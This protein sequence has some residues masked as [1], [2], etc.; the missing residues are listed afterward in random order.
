[1]S[2]LPTRFSLK[3]DKD[4]LGLTLIHPVLLFVFADLNLY[5]MERSLPLV[6]TRII[7]ERIDGV[8]VSD[9]HEEGRAIDVSLI[10]WTT[11]DIDEVIYRFN[12]KYAEAYGAYS[13][14]DSKPRLIVDPRHGTAPHLHIQIRK[15][16]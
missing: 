16:R 11:D 9:T 3:Y 15:F 10:G 8:S 13:Y 6:I 5:C 1:M 4:M 7:D 12:A 2:D 14:S